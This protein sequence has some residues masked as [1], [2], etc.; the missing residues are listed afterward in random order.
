MKNPKAYVWSFIGKF[1]GQFLS[2]LTTLILARLLTPADFG[3]I[4]VL[5]VV[6][7][8]ANTLTDSG[9]GGALMMEKELNRENCGTIFVFNL[10]ISISLCVIIFFAAPYIEH[11]YN[12]SGLAKITR[13]LCLVF[14]FNAFGMVPK[15]IL[16]YQLKFKELSLIGLLS[17]LIASVMAIG[18]AYCGIGVWALVAMQLFSTL[19]STVSAYSI[20]HYRFSICFSRQCF[21]RMF[22]F[23]VFTTVANVIDSVY[24]N[25]ATVIFGKFLTVAD[26]G[27]LTQAKKIEETSSQSLMMTVNITSYPILSKLKDDKDSFAKEADSLLT[28]IPLMMA[29]ILIIVGVYSREVALLLLGE[30]WLDSASYL[31]IL[32][33][34]GY[35]MMNE[36]IS[37]NFLKSLGEVRVLFISTIIKRVIGC[38]LLLLIAFVSVD[39]ILIGYVVGAF[40]GYLVT[41]YAYAKL[42]RQ[43]YWEMQYRMVLKTTPL[44][45]LLCIIKADYLLIDCLPVNIA[46]SVIVFAVYYLFVL[47]KMGIPVKNIINRIREKYANHSKTP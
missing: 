9:L 17:T 30:K 15:S 19:I 21:N 6:F 1:G 46:V 14:L 33:F 38:A 27:Y 8:V 13:A 20:S 25:V 26:A 10:V 43:N 12:V 29:P 11:F 3:T 28:V 2:L 7:V 47:P 5:S 40:S 36:S 37:R 32:V 31:G 41:S 44:L 22:S 45:C 24:E 18:L 23:G 42:I 35:F 4:G 34:A 16:T 39:L